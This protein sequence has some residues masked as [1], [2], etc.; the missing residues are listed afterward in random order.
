[1]RHSLHVGTTM[2]EM[3]LFL[4]IVAIMSTTIVTVYIATQE[5]R[6]RQRVIAEVEQRGTQLLETMTK[7]IRHAERVLKPLGSQTGSIVALQMA[8]NGSFPTL[9]AGTSSGNLLLVQ[10][11]ST[12]ALLG[13]NIHITDLVF[14]ATGERNITFSFELI[15]NVQ[16]IPP[17]TYSQM[18]SG[19]A[20]LFPDDQ[21]EAGGCTSCPLPACTNGR[22]QWYHCAN[23]TC[24]MSPTTIE[25]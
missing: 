7:T 19:T 18:F 13:D 12:A 24:A 10:K 1:M 6:V 2:L 9:F 25:C 4:G 14:R 21:S 22:Y 23:D 5:A 3:I 8:L 15:G 16:S 20:T 17:S 11:T